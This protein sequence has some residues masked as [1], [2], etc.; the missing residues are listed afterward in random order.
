MQVTVTRGT[1]KGKSGK[2]IQVYRRKWVIHVEAIQ[3]EKANGTQVNIGL[4]PSK[5]LLVSFVD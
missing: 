1:F 4:D 5:V 2:V 3:R